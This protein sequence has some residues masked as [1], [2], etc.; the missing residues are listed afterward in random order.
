MDI[1]APQKRKKKKTEADVL[2]YELRSKWIEAIFNRHDITHADFRVLYFIAKRS[3]H[4][5]RGCFWSVDAIAKK[6]QCS[7][8]TVSEATAKAGKEKWLTVEKN[9]GRKN[10]YAPIFFW[11]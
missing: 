11:L 9:S 7:T 8:K 1:S 2:Y 4:E 10:F 3:G 6:C 5:Y